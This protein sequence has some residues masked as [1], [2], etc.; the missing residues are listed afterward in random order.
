MNDSDDPEGAI[1]VQLIF[2]VF[3]ILIN[4]FFAAA[5]IALVSI[6]KNRIS[7]LA[8]AGNRSAQ[9]LEKLIA[10]PSQF[11]AAIQV[12]ITL[13]TFFSSASAATGVASYFSNFLIGIP[14]SKEISIIFIT[15][16]LSFITLVLGELFPK[17]LA[18]QNAEQIAFLSV[19]PILFICKIALPFVKLLS[20]STDL[21]VKIT[22][23]GAQK[24][25]K[26]K[27]S[28]EEIRLLAQ[29]G[30]ADGSIN[31][32]EFQMINGVFELDNKIAREIMTPRTAVFRLNVNTP[33]D[34]LA[35]LILNEK[36]SRIP[37]YEEDA[38]RII[39]IL[40]IKD[41]FAAARKDG[42]ENV[43]IRSLLREPYFVPE[44]KF[45]DDL[46]RELQMTQNHLAIIIDEYG[47]FSGIV[48]IEDLL[49]EIVGE[50]E[51]EY[52]EIEEELIQLSEH[53][54]LAKGTMSIDHFNEQFQTH[55]SVPNIDTISGF[56][57]D[58]IGMI[59]DDQDHVTIE[60]EQISFTVESV[61]E[62]RIE[63]IR[64]EDKRFMKDTQQ[65]YPVSINP[66]NV[67]IS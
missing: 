47:G 53:V 43:E 30:R 4:G 57:L 63:T 22:G 11:L 46:L 38:D 17:R 37:F 41:Y 6:N 55:I 3:L 49:E 13:A 14:Y 42:F 19:R 54:Y 56:L 21:I 18:I 9:L 40:H 36:Y 34:K 52:D 7:S 28:R 24:K 50:I 64:I 35:D 39:G 1:F 29:A 61:K 27:V 62:N 67:S 33:P 48:T 60:Y 10:D 32:K 23:L 59:P 20:F 15:F 2:I 31:A 65:R 8:L 25:L 66:E 16:L 51:D 58:K 12:G 45:I 26:K 5:E 44:T